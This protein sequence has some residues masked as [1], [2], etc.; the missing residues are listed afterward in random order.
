MGVCMQVHVNGSWHEAWDAHEMGLLPALQRESEFIDFLYNL[1]IDGDR[2]GASAHAYDVHGVTVSG[3]GD[4]KVLNAK[5][6]RQKHF[7]ALA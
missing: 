5:F 6:P 4:S 2:P 3:L 1:E 7:K